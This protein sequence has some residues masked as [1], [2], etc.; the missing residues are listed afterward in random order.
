M[1][2]RGLLLVLGESLLPCSVFDEVNVI[3]KDNIKIFYLALVMRIVKEI[4][5]LQK[6]INTN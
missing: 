5:G 6:L 1:S 2:L 4:I 3:K